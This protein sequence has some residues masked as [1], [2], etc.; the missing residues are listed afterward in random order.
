MDHIILTPINL[1]KPSTINGKK[2]KND[3]LREIS[4]SSSFKLPS[5][6]KWDDSKHNTAK[7]GNYFGFVHQNR[8]KNI[9]EIFRIE[10]IILAIHR[11]N[12]W[13]IIEHKPRNVLILSEKIDEI[14]WSDYKEQNNY[15]ENFVLQGTSRLKNNTN[16]Y[17]N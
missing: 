9:I 2:A 10:K 7:V 13:D 8:N 14:S 11:P 1:D 3:Y 16:F 12:Y 6:A 5:T 15:K 4:N 17:G